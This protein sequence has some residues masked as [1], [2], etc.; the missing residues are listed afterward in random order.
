MAASQE[1]LR[2]MAGDDEPE[3]IEEDE[4]IEYDSTCRQFELDISQRIERDTG[5]LMKV[6]E[7]QPFRVFAQGQLRYVGRFRTRMSFSGH[8]SCFFA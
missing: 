7:L 4:D 6:G 3:I 8:G 2:A 5:V 1:S